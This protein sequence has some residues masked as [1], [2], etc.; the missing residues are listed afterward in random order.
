[1]K[2]QKISVIIPIYNSEEYLNKCITSVISQT[3]SSI[4]I[5]LV[6]DGSTDDSLNICNYY[7]KTDSRIKVISQENR[8]VASARNAGMEQ[9]TGDFIG[10]VDSDD[11][12][13]YDMYEKL[14]NSA[15][16]Y[17]AD[18]VE[19]GYYTT[20]SDYKVV[21]INNLKN[22]VIK[23]EYNCIQNYIKEENTTN[24][25]V[26]K[27]Y[28]RAILEGLKYPNYK[29]SED[30]YMNVMAHLRCDTKVIISDACYY[31]HRH[32]N[33]AT[34]KNIS[35]YKFDVINSGKEV[36]G[37]INA[38]YP[39]LSIYVVLYIL[40]NIR[41]LYKQIIKLRETEYDI[42]KSELIHE[43]INLYDQWKGKIPKATKTK[44]NLMALKLFRSFR[45]LHDFIEQVK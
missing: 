1:M 32:S 41:T 14:I 30:F 44:K 26:N 31:Y 36:L 2:S 16:K 9:A 6:N 15:E 7:S 11:Y 18:I 4:E 20:D 39:E 3:Y 29:Y 23:G 35:K 22:D 40:N 37:I 17:H 19:C 10:F 43:Y 42:Y 13:S 38:K 5:I 12:I 45:F 27:I 24:Y 28:R 8:G 33:S 25:N 34:L 21:A